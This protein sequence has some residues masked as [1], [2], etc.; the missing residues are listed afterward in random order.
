MEKNNGNLRLNV[1]RIQK[2]PTKITKGTDRLCV[3]KYTYIYLWYG[4]MNALILLKIYI[5]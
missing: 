2:K 1:T 4:Y 5:L 3:I